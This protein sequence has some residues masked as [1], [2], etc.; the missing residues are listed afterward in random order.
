MYSTIGDFVAA[1]ADISSEKKKSAVR[2]F[3]GTT[4]IARVCWCLLLKCGCC[5]FARIFY[6]SMHMSVDIKYRP[7]GDT[8]V[9][10]FCRLMSGDAMI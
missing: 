7:V 6:H 8:W 1:L 2:L 4:C 5:S 10:P 9:M 3:V